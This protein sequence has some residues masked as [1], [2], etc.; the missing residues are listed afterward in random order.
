MFDHSI[1]DIRF[2]L[3]RASEVREHLLLALPKLGASSGAS[4]RVLSGFMQG[5]SRTSCSFLC[6]FRL[7]LLSIGLQIL[8]SAVDRVPPPHFGSPS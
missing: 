3:S 5:L 1:A 4:S 8:G 7:R 6:G 2:T